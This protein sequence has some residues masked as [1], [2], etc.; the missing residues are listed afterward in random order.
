MD[1]KRFFDAIRE[2][3]EGNSQEEV[4]LVLRERLQE[5]LLALTYEGL[6]HFRN[7]GVSEES[8]NVLIEA[9]KNMA[10]GKEEAFSAAEASVR[11]IYGNS[12]AEADVCQ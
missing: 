6:L 2:C 4:P 1:W 12:G 11:S 8:V 5:E 7:A 9:L 10:D 3:C